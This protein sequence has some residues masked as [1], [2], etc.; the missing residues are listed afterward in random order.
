[1]G[2]IKYID[3]SFTFNLLEGVLSSTGGI[4]LNESQKLSPIKIIKIEKGVHIEIQFDEIDFIDIYH[5]FNNSIILFD[6]HTIKVQN[7]IISQRVDN[8]VKGRISSFEYKNFIK[9]KDK[10]HRL[11]LP[12]NSTPNFT[13]SVE[14]VPLKYKYKSE[15]LTRDAIEISENNNKFTLFLAKKSIAELQED[16]FLILESKNKMPFLK[17]SE[18]CFSILL[19]FGLASGFFLMM[20]AFFFSMMK[21]KCLIQLA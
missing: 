16:G 9:T 8:L 5:D 12:I 17:F 21:K 15:V 13:F 7:L 19:S 10:Y 18:H 20:M 11:V 6:K 3:L 4:S 2:K 14:N 1:M